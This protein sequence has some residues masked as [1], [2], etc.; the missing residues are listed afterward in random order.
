MGI[1]MALVQKP[2]LYFTQNA[3]TNYILTLHL[4]YKQAAKDRALARGQVAPCR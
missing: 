4:L 3:I 2:Y 1:R